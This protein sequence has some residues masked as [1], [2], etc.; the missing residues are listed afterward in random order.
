LSESNLSGYLPTSY[1]ISAEV[2]FVMRLG[3]L[4]AYEARIT[5]R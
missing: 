2:G 3:L 4:C 1:G 5:N